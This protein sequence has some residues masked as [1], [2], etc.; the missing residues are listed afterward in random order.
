MPVF[1]WKAS[2]IGFINSS[3][4][5]EYITRS[6]SVVWVKPAAAAVVAEAA[7]PVV[8]AAV[9]VAAVVAALEL[10]VLAAVVAAGAVVAVLSPHA[11][12]KTVKS[13]S[14]VNTNRPI[15]VF[16]GAFILSMQLFYKLSKK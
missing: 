1:F 13:M 16:T 5:A 6:L 9:V 10:V 12:N 2:T 15:K 3:L 4:R 8:P 11:V 14:V 7:A